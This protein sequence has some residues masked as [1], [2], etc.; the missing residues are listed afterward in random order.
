MSSDILI[1]DEALA[2]GDAQFV[3]KCMLRF[4]QLQKEGK[5]IILVTHDASAVKTLC[6]RAIWLDQGELK[7]VGPSSE[8]V[9]QY[10][11]KIFKHAEWK[12]SSMEAVANENP[13]ED[14]TDSVEFNSIPLKFDERIGDGIFEIL[15]CIL[16]DS[17]KN[18]T[19]S[20]DQNENVQIRLTFKNNSEIPV[21][22]LIGLILKDPKGIE[23]ASSISRME[24]FRYTTLAPNEALSTTI[25]FKIP[26]L[27]PGPYSIT[28]TVSYIDNSEDKIADRLVNALVFEIVSSRECHTLISL[29]ASYKVNTKNSTVEPRNIN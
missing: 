21:E 23:I 20:I 11:N 16:L 12:N 15:S 1:V 17:E 8:V 3:H 2:V 26:R 5:T 18:L 29:D 4:H 24:K 25:E 6:S 22:P 14:I 10:L 13:T 7:A 9:D 27:Y 28:P 19:N